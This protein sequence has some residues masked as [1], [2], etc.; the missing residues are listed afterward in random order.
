VSKRSRHRRTPDQCRRR[1]GATGTGVGIAVGGAM[2]AAF[3]SMGTAS[4]DD[5][6]GS[7]GGDVTALAQPVDLTA[8]TAAADP[9]AAVPAQATFDAFEELVLTIDPDAFSSTTGDPTDFIGTL[10]SEIDADVG[11]IDF[12]TDVEGTDVTLNT[13]AG[14][15]SCLIAATCT[16]VLSTVPTTGD[17]GFTVLEQ[18]VADT[19]VPE[20][21]PAVFVSSVDTDLTTIAG[22]L[23]SY[24]SGTVFGPDI[25]N[26]A[27]YIIS[28][29]TPAAADAAAFVP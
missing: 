26:I 22:D 13:I 4:A 23:D 28:A 18:F 21:V 9:A 12:G 2:A 7:A 3:V 25:Y 24:F 15:L 6:L 27:E 14:Q 19:Y 1:W 10:A 8:V 11:S 5:L 16:D 17:D 29:L 20:V